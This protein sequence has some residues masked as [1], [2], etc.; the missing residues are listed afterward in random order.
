MDDH[1]GP[2]E[3]AFLFALMRGMSI[4]GRCPPALQPE[5]V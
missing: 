2:C 3:G 5:K 1:W 4:L